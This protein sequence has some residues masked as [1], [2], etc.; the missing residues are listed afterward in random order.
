MGSRGKRR[1]PERQANPSWRGLEIGTSDKTD[2]VKRKL[3]SHLKPREGRQ[4]T[5]LVLSHQESAFQ[6]GEFASHKVT[7]AMYHS[8]IGVQAEPKLVAKFVDGK[9]WNP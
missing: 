1:I 9:L 6:I 5:P 3:N 2:M 7:A 8:R 4:D